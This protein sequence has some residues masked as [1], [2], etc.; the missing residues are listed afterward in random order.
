MP[1][2]EWTRSNVTAYLCENR[3]AAPQIHKVIDIVPGGRVGTG[4]PNVNIVLIHPT[5]KEHVQLTMSTTICL[6]VPAYAQRM[7]VMI[8]SYTRP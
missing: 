2:S 7:G 3:H 4:N 1:A 5:T 6:F 8:R